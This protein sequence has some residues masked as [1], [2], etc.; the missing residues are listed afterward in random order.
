ML[1]LQESR[2]KIDVI[3]QKLVELFEERM[4]LSKEVAQYKL[5]NGKKVH[6]PD[7]ETEKL[8]DLE[9]M[10]NNDFNRHGIRE[11][12]T[13]IM[14]M[15]RKLQYGMIST[16]QEADFKPVSQLKLEGKK[17][18]FYG[19][20]G[21]YTEQAME[22]YF[23]TEVESF[24]SKTFQEVMEAIKDGHAHYGVLP[25]E[26]SSTGGITDIYDLLAQYDHSIVGEHVVKVD[27]ALLGLPGARLE[28]IRTV[29][30][31]PQGLLQCSEFL[32][33]HPD[34]RTVEYFS[35]SESAKKV[36]ED[37]DPSQGAIASMRAAEFYGLEAI[38]ES[39]HTDKKNKTRF[40]IV[41]GD[42]E[43]FRDANKVS[44]CFLLPHESGS[45]YNML[46]HMIYNNLNMTK[47][48][49]RPIPEK[50]WEYRF[51]VDFEGDLQDAGVRNALT[52]I[53]EEAIE[54]KIL[55]NYRTN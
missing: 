46:S 20:R 38:C 16:M 3:D 31:H 48:E 17:V 8:N 39:I 27:Q 22:E 32:K 28:D 1:D 2:N 24:T 12:F 51:F 53:R 43:Y 19:A 14:A 49:S 54:L 4:K 34:I 36:L 55:G 44:I 26:N 6:D 50:N 30:S 37:S 18:V 42:K 23:G 52:G 33:R 7:R 11:L 15:S 5:A 40:I 45:L 10:A 29:Y 25:I 13:Q 9:N 47:I 41:G 21:S 35:T